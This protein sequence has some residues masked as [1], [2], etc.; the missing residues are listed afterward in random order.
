M[1]SLLQVP[2][3]AKHPGHRLAAVCG[4]K[5]MLPV[6]GGLTKPEAGFALQGRKQQA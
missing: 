2:P 3:L 6:N 5:E 4:C 1:A